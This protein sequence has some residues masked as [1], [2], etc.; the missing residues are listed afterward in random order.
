MQC[1]AD[2]TTE[3]GEARQNIGAVSVL[4]T[5]VAIRIFDFVGGAFE[6]ALL[7]KQSSS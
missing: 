2:S 5:F 1:D 7:A 4:W 3:Q 6:A